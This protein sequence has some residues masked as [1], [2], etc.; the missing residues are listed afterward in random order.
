MTDRATKTHDQRIRSPSAPVSER[1][2]GG[3]D[4]SKWLVATIPAAS[5]AT[6]TTT[7]CVLTGTCAQ[8]H[9]API[10]APTRPPTL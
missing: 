6:L 1:A 7:S 2:A 4:G 9:A 8:A 5:T 3:A 10:A